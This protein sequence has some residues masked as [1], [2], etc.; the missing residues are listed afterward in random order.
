[1]KYYIS[2][3]LVRKGDASKGEPAFVS[4][5]KILTQ[6]D[7][8]KNTKKRFDRWKEIG[9]EDI[10]LVLYE[11]RRYKRLM[12]EQK[13]KTKPV[14]LQDIAEALVHEEDKEDKVEESGT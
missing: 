5:E 6:V 3:I 11:A 12:K 14:Q 13:R 9:M 2:K 7:T 1:M 10:Y 4:T 8:L